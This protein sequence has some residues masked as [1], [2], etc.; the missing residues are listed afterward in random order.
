MLFPRLSEFSCGRSLK[1]WTHKIPYQS[2]SGQAEDVHLNTNVKIGSRIILCVPEYRERVI[3]SSRKTSSK[4]KKAKWKHSKCMHYRWTEASIPATNVC[5]STIIW[6]NLAVH[7]VE[8]Q[9]K[10]DCV[11]LVQSNCG[12]Y[13]SLSL[14]WN[15]S[16]KPG[17][18]SH[19]SS[20]DKAVSCRP[21]RPHSC[22]H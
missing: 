14:E 6:S 15:C 5:S 21:W 4:A 7:S 20:Y 2:H 16:E 9:R 10:G 12:Q 3:F 18:T 11:S 22:P 1:I 19:G 17:S 13:F 8:F